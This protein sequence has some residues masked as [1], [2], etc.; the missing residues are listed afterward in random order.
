MVKGSSRQVLAGWRR[1]EVDG[2]GSVAVGTDV[3]VGVVDLASGVRVAVSRTAGVVVS[4]LK[5]VTAT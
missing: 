5:V 1:G 2:A 4:S 3:S